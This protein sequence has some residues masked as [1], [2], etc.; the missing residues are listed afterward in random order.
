MQRVFENARRS[1]PELQIGEFFAQGGGAQVFDQLVQ[2]LTLRAFADDQGMHISKRLID[3]QIAQV[4]AFQDAAGNFSNDSFRALL[5]RERLSEQALRDLSAWV[6]KGVAP[7]ANTAYRIDHGQVI[8]PADA[9]ARGGIQPV[10]SVTA[11]GAAKA[12]VKPGTPVTFRATISVP[13]GAGRIVSAEWDFD[14]SGAFAEKAKL[15]GGS[16]S[17]LT[18]TTRHSFTA[19]GTY[20]PALRIASERKG[21]AATPYARIQNLG[22]VRVVVE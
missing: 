16:G 3:A 15:P 2:S 18:L 13:P 7:P 5:A 4:P 22:R 6:E 12:V 21:N 14:G 8:V 9:A 10:A 1:S 20:F 19:P 11:N 17:S